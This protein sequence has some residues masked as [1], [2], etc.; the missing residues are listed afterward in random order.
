MAISYV[1]HEAAFDGALT[2]TSLRLLMYLGGEHPDSKKWSKFWCWESWSD[3]A[4]HLSNEYFHYSPAM[5]KSALYLLKRQGYLERAVRIILPRREG[6]RTVRHLCYRVIISLEDRRPAV[7][8]MC[9][10]ER[11]HA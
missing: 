2:P 4:R 7:S 1:P 6:G 5:I 9:A 11:K 3:L 8:D 10:F